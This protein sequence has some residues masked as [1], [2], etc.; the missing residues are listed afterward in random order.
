MRPTLHLLQES[1]ARSSKFRQ[2]SASHWEQLDVH[3]VAPSRIPRSALQILALVAHGQVVE[4]G[5]S[6][7][8]T[9]ADQ[10]AAEQS[11]HNEEINN[12]VTC[13]TDEKYMYSY[14][15]TKQ[16]NMMPTEAKV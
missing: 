14:M 16:D 11:S 9:V 4:G 13:Q 7:E 10:A 1:S 8:L 2:A 12:K 5:A 6:R 3:A 15:T